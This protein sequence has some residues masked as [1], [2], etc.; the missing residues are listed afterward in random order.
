MM[1]TPAPDYIFASH[2]GVEANERWMESKQSLLAAAKI[3]PKK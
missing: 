2:V 3:N 1:K